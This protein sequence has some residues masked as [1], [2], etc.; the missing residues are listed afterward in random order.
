M[1]DSIAIELNTLLQARSNKNIKRTTQNIISFST[2]WLNLKQEGSTLRSNDL[3]FID[4]P[5]LRFVFKNIYLNWRKQFDLYFIHPYKI[6]VCY[7]KF[8]LDHMILYDNLHREIYRSLC[9]FEFGGVFF[10]LT[11]GMQDAVGDNCQSK[12]NLLTIKLK[13]KNDV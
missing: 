7:F 5:N 12:C 3:R 13:G 11:G 1:R 9:K 4:L 10:S 8:L 2:F 6:S